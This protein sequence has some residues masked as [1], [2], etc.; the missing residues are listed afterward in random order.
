MLGS[1]LPD[2]GDGIDDPFAE[3]HFGARPVFGRVLE[4]PF[5]V[6]LLGGQR[7][8]QAGVIFGQP[9]DFV[10]VHAEHDFAHHRRGCVV[11]MDNR[12]PGP[13]Q[14]LKGAPDK[15]LACLSQDLHRDVVRNQIFF[16]EGAQK[17]ELG[18]RRTRETHFDVFEPDL[19][20]L[21]KHALLA[22]DVHRLD[23][24][25]VAI[26]QIDAAPQ[27][28]LGDH[29]IRPGAVGQFHRLEGAIFLRGV[30]EHHLGSRWRVG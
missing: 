28:R 4:G 27:R 13:T 24:R 19:D 30:V 5:R 1:G 8:Q 25:L 17:V 2:G 12:R 21:R 16:N 22:V 26:T 6:G 20:Q 14:R 23:Q 29:R 18:L 15:M 3:F 10:L 7:L 11:Q 9:D